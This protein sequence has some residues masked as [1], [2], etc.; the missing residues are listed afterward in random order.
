MLHMDDDMM[1][2]PRLIFFPTVERENRDY[3]RPTG[4]PLGH[5]YEKRTPR[6]YGVRCGEQSDLPD[7]MVGEYGRWKEFIWIIHPVFQWR[8]PR[9]IQC[10]GGGGAGVRLPTYDHLL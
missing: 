9:E 2:E 1:D 5:T 7:E 3:H 10:W 6:F 8:A 4:D